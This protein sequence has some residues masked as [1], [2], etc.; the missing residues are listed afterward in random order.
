MLKTLEEIASQVDPNIGVDL[1]ELTNLRAGRLPNSAPVPPEELEDTR[2]ALGVA[3]ESGT[4]EYVGWNTYG[5][6][7]YAPFSPGRRG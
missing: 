4:W 5:E 7:A 6:M 3:L 2:D 1:W